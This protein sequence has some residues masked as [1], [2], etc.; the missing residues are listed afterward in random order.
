MSDW[1]RP[2]H[3]RLRTI[4]VIV[5]VAACAAALFVAG[6]WSVRGP[7]IST[8]ASESRPAARML[9]VDERGIPFGYSQTEAGARSAAVNILVAGLWLR[10]ASGSWDLGVLEAK[11]L[12][13]VGSES[14]ATELLL[15]KGAVVCVGLSDNCVD[16]SADNPQRQIYDFSP[17]VSTAGSVAAARVEYE[18][19]VQLS[20]DGLE[21]SVV[22]VWSE[23]RQFDDGE[24]APGLTSVFTL[25]LRWVDDWK[26]LPDG[27][28]VQPVTDRAPVP[29][30][31]VAGFI[32]ETL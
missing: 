32:G 2:R 8:S 10:Q 16:H 3:S 5:V 6:R 18:P 31:S 24:S 25:R 20:A 12:K 27:V 28:D 17:P 1:A 19:E 22:L 11:G 30:L 14:P 23:Q 9:P 15:N 29:W 13:D 4:V 21:A 7:D 26:L